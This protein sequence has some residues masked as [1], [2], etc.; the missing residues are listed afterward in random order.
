[1]TLTPLST[2]NCQRKL[3][4]ARDEAGVPHVFAESRD[5]ALYGLGY[6]HATDRITQIMFARAVSAGRASELIADKEE[7]RETDRFFRRIG[8]HR[9]HHREVTLLQ[10]HIHEQIV[11]YAAGVN[12]GAMAVGQSW[13]MWATGFAS[14]PWDPVSVLLIGNL[15]SFGGLAVSQLE[16]ERI[17]VELIQSGASEAALREMFEGRLE[18][19][20]FDLIRHV[21][22]LPRMSDEA[23]EVLADL[24]RLAGSN[25][26]AVAPSRTASGGALLC[27]D[28]HLEINRLPAIWY[29]AVLNWGDDYVM[30]ATLP[31]CPLVAVGR[32]SNLAWGVTYMK[33]DTID[34]FIEDCRVSPTGQWQ[35]RRGAHTWMDFEV[36]EE[37][38]GRKGADAETMIVLENPQGTLDADPLTPGYQFSLAWSG[39]T[40]GS[41]TAIGSWLDVIA[42]SDVV[43]AMEVAE[44][45][46]QPTLCWVFADAEGNI[47]M[48]G[49]GRFPVRR[50]GAT[51][52]APLAAWDEANH[53]NGFLSAEYLPSIYNPECGFVATANEEQPEVDGVRVTSQ[54]LPD[55]RKRR[56]VEQLSYAD[57]VTVEEMQALQYDL[58]SL[59]ARDLLPYLLPHVADKSIVRRLENWSL[60]YSPDSH[61]AVLFQ[62]L[63]RNTLLEIFGQAEGLGRRRVL[64]VASRVGFSSMVIAAVDRILKKEE[65]LWWKGRDKGELIRAA[66]EKLKLEVEKPWSEV[67]NFHFTDR[68]FGGISVG[69]L[70]GFESRPYPMPGNF[71]TIF[72]GHV[73]Q[74]AKRSSTFAPSYHFVADMATSE[75]WSNLPGGPSESRFSTFYK[76]DVARWFEGQYKQLINEELPSA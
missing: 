45:C 40:P 71:A 51:G 32:T 75:A 15:L 53:W 9:N 31:G 13:P 22:S 76:S 65:S 70:L 8:L 54:T 38:L 39:T 47:G 26:W 67:N 11:H 69:R 29:E 48:Q 1:M 5:D 63:Y 62:R 35:Y 68:F 49:N 17:V 61:E 74:T 41:G 42:S 59:Q 4:I 72:Q 19:V 46:P 7:L 33:G 18:H 24:P 57:E 56:I 6:M 55:Y 52:L 21:P 16:N 60:D 23:L 28:P 27:S 14:E 25:A 2:P 43:S 10:P 37:I 73:L 36:R 30:G 44:Q 50:S 66:A 34:I 58:V 12:D 3:R 20:D 64:Y